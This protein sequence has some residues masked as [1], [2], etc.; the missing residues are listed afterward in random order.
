MLGISLLLT[1]VGVL[2]CTARNEISSALDAV[3]T[4]DQTATVAF[5]IIEAALSATAIPTTTGSDMGTS[6]S[7]T[8]ATE[9][10]EA[11]NVATAVA[12][13]LNAQPVATPTPDLAATQTMEAQR[14]VAAIAA[15]LTAQ[16]TFTPDQAATQTRQVHVV[17]TIVAATL[18][19]QP[20]ATATDIPTAVPQVVAYRADEPKLQNLS[21]LWS[22]T[23]FRD[24]STP[25]I[26]TYNVVVTPNQDWRWTFA[27]CAIDSDTL[28]EILQP[29]TVTMLIDEVALS[30]STILQHQGVSNNHDQCYY[31]STALTNWQPGAVVKLE[32]RYFLTTPIYDGRQSYPAGQYQQVMFVNVR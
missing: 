9:T 18:T 5:E 30:N 2:G 8:D 22:L 17:E 12:A 31:W 3:A 26:Q 13:T 20:R 6:T 4:I 16:P 19:A 1:L 11:Q 32:I 7:D 29:L 23:S 15:T 10:V 28:H 25:S 24:L 27:W 21:S 14:V